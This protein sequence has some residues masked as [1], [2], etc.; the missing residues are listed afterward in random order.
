VSRVRAALPVAAFVVLTSCGQQGTPVQRAL[1]DTAARLDRIRSASMDL[2][3]AAESPGAKGPV[4]FA[5]KGPFA[6][7]DKP[8]L[9]VANLAVTE[10][11]GAEKYEASFVST[12][13]QAYV[14]RGSRTVALP[15]GTSFDL[16]GGNGLGALRI[17]RWLRSPRLSGGGTVGG[18]ATERIAAGLDVAAAFDDLGRLGERL[19]T[20]ALAGLRPLDD[21]AKAQL[22]RAASSSSIEVWTGTKDRLLRRLVLRVTLAPGGTLPAALR[23]MVPVTL[24]FTLGLSAVNEP[25]HVD[26]PAG[27]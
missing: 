20:S 5:M 3:M 11:R 17:D 26:P 1:R 22:A 8:G 12:G 18:V 16:Q 13:Q 21:A 25:V 19:G 9:P 15:S 27:A 14:V 24:S 4:G 23:R 2:T 7:P 6:L 10:L